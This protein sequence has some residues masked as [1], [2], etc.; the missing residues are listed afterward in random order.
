MCLLF[1]YLKG[2]VYWVMNQ[3]CSFGPLEVCACVFVGVEGDRGG[4][5]AISV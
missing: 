1:I 2:A 3:L 5:V 4:V